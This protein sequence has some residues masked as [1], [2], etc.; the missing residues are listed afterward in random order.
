MDS[1]K[2]DFE[3]ME[4]LDPDAIRVGLD[5]SYCSLQVFPLFTTAL[6]EKH[7]GS[8]FAEVMRIVNSMTEFQMSFEIWVREQGVFRSDWF[9]CRL[10]FSPGRFVEYVEDHPEKLRRRIEGDENRMI[11]RFS[12]L[13]ELRMKLRLSGV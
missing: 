8:W 7:L 3:N 6:A 11:P 10:C 9:V 5:K 4:V 13:P 1:K 12:S 2:T